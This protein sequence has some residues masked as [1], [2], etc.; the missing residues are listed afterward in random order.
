MKK[1]LL[2]GDEDVDL[3]QGKGEVITILVTRTEKCPC[4][5][6]DPSETLVTLSF[7][8]QSPLSQ[9]ATASVLRQDTCL[10]FFGMALC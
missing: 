9:S 10:L 5:A 2:E 3:P 8:L 6:N 4:W 1:N 7:A